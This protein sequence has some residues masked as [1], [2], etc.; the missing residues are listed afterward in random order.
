MRLELGQNQ[1]D[2]LPLSLDSTALTVLTRG[3]PEPGCRHSYEIR[4][5][6]PAST[7]EDPKGSRCP[8]GQV[9]ELGMALGDGQSLG[10][11]LDTNVLLSLFLFIYLLI[12]GGTGV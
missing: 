5:G 9:R 3:C 12:F 6:A 7:A 4:S 8:L 11:D 10:G 1:E 2:P